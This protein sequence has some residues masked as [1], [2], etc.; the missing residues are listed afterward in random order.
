MLFHLLP[1]SLSFILLCSITNDAIWFRAFM[2]LG[3]I[4]LLLYAFLELKTDYIPVIILDTLIVMSHL[5]HLVDL[6]I[7]KQIHEKQLEM[8]SATNSTIELLKT[9]KDSAT[10]KNVD[11][12]SAN[13]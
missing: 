4:V 13:V 10:F 6:I 1:I 2:F 3:N 9:N 12:L 7:L 8:Y 5:Y 11:E